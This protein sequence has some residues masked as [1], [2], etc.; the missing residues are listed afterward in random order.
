MKRMAQSDLL[1]RLL[2]ARPLVLAAA[3]FLAGC[4]CAY[5]LNV[6]PAASAAAFCALL[7]S[8]CCFHRQSKRLIPILLIAAMLPLGALRFALSWQK[9]EPLP[10][11][12]VSPAAASARCRSTKPRTS[13]RYA[14]LRRSLSMAHPFP[15]AFAYTCA[16][17]KRF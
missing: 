6:P 5:A 16:A 14:S 8:A 1:A 12:T 2:H 17:M 15:A 13:A 7:L 9:T 3:V 10:D 11:Q 4:I